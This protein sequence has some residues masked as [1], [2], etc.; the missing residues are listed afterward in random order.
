M[1]LEL[2]LQKDFYILFTDLINVILPIIN[3]YIV[4]I[5][6]IKTNRLY[7]IYQICLSL[8]YIMIMYRY[9]VLEKIYFDLDVFYWFL[10]EALIFGTFI[11]LHT[12][13]LKK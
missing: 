12:K 3:I 1:I 2:I 7:Y 13:D 9:S 10:F 4:S 11:Y 6:L 5:L 8:F